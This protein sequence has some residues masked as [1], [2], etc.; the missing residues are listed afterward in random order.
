MRKCIYCL[1]LERMRGMSN[2]PD[3]KA[4][5]IT[6]KDKLIALRQSSPRTQ[7]ELAAVGGVSNVWNGSIRNVRAVGF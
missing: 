3:E 6:L 5:I 2:L 4:E 1:Y 7:Q